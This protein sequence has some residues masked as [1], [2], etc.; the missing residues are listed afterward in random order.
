[1]WNNYAT[2]YLVRKENNPV[3]VPL[4]RAELIQKKNKF[5]L[6]TLIIVRGCLRVMRD[7]FQKI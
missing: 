4:K 7:A 1:M 2:Q 5:K 3:N 6:F